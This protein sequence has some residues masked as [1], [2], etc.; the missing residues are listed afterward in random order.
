MYTLNYK[1]EKK[2]KKLDYLSYLQTAIIYISYNL[3]LL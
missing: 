3:H 1:D 2:H